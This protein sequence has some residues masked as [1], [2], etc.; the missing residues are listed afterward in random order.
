MLLVPI[1]WFT[2]ELGLCCVIAVSPCLF[3]LIVW[4]DC[5]VIAL[6]ADCYGL[7]VVVVSLVW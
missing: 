6:F 1:V 2:F 5:L 3:S 4:L 7:W